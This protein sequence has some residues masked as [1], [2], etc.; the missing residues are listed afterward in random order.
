[1]LQALR[2]I[3]AAIRKYFVDYD[4]GYAFDS[5]GLNGAIPPTA[6]EILSDLDWTSFPTFPRDRPTEEILRRNTP[7]NRRL[8]PVAI[9]GRL[10][11][12]G[13]V[14]APAAAAG[15]ADPQGSAPHQAGVAA[16]VPQ[17]RRRLPPTFRPEAD[18]DAE[19]SL[20]LR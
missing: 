10:P 14:P 20:V 4:W 3:V 13:P 7:G 18:S 19:P 17:A 1:M 9:A 2:D 5:L 11:R 8:D 15:P 16:Q 12:V 6:R